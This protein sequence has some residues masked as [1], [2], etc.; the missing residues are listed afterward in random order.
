MGG[1]KLAEMY[2][3]SNLMALVG[4]GQAPKFSDQN[5]EFS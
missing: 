1:I 3:N 2:Y 5:G 4:G